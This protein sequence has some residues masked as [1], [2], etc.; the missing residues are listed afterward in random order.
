M[1]VN[2]C[3]QAA[4]VASLNFHNNIIRDILILHHAQM[5]VVTTITNFLTPSNGQNAKVAYMCYRMN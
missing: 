4:A 1:V 3:K 2:H 5:P